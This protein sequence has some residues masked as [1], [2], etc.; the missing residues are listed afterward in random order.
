MRKKRKNNSMFKSSEEILD[1]P[2]AMACLMGNGYDRKQLA[3]PLIAVIYNENWICPGHNNLKRLALKAAEGI[4]EAGGTPI[5]MNVG[6]GI[7]DGIAMGHDGM[8]YSLLSS[9]LNA[10]CVEAMVRAQK[11]FSGLVMIAACD[12]NIPGYL[13][14]TARLDMPTIFITA[15]PMMPGLSAEGKRLDVVDSFKAR[16]AFDGGKMSKEEYL[17]IIENSCPGPGTC[18]GL[19]TACS[20]ACNTEALGMSLPGM[21]TSHAVDNKKLRLCIETGRTIMRLVKKG[22]TARQILNDRAFEN[23]LIVDMAI[24]ASTNTIIHLPIIAQ[25]AGEAISLLTI[26][27]ISEKVPNIVKISPSSE[28]K[29]IDL[30]TAGGI[31][32]VMKTLH[33]L[34]LDNLTVEGDIESRLRKIKN[35]SS[36]VIRSLKYPYS[37]TGGI[38]IL[39]GSLAPLGAVIKQSGVGEGVPTMAEWE[40]RVFD[41][42]EDATAYINSGKLKKDASK[43]LIAI[44]IRYEGPAGGPGM[45]EMLYVTSAIVKL[46]LDKR[47]ALI[48][49]GRFS[50]G[51]SGPCIGHVSPEAY[52]GGSIA[53]VNDGDRIWINL[54]LKRLDL[55][56]PAGCLNE[57][58]KGWK[59][60]EKFVPKGGVLEKYKNKVTK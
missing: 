31:P 54:N 6:L 43:K 59:R 22:I 38:S 27:N 10:D 40:A 13:R 1:L 56:V 16:A 52:N 53:L 47:V 58:H 34:L 41:S 25:E 19:F 39:T 42:E 4:V 51:T 49:D 8:R 60:V 23:A 30:E 17:D 46:G 32:V 12:K 37:K 2:A 18:A 7:C 29:M 26:N 9:D 35:R 55:L 48:T 15:G 33:H 14:A 24:G 36:S 44:I 11:I 57:R 21:A 50:G 28:F 3:R 45:R 5:P 20:M